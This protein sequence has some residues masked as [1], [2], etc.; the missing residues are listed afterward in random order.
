VDA[1]FAVPPRVAGDTGPAM[2][3]LID[4]AGQ[5]GLAVT[6][7]G[8]GHPVRAGRT[9]HLALL[10][11]EADPSRVVESGTSRWS[12]RAALEAALEAAERRPVTSFA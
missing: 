8:P 2:E 1:L 3:A 6:L 5:L 11:D 12:H 9:V 7:S 4:R 10:W